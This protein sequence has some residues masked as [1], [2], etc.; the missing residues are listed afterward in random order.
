MPCLGK[1]DRLDG[2]QAKDDLSAM[3]QVA[4]QLSDEDLQRLKAH[5]EA[6]EMTPEGVAAQ[7]VEALLEGD[8]PWR[9][10]GTEEKYRAFVQKGI[11]SADRG[12]LEDWDVV[13][14][15]LRAYMT[16]RSAEAAE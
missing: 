2:A 3:A 12:D 1:P 13:K 8:Q 16:D 9:G 4:I 6:R 5:A 7:A 11:D 14:A 10:S 15:R